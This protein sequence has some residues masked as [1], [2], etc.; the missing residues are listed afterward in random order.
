M[1]A[2]S[3]CEGWRCKGVWVFVTRLCP[4][5]LV[6]IVTA[7]LS[8][9]WPILSLFISQVD[10]TVQKGAIPMVVSKPKLVESLLLSQTDP[11]KNDC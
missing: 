9:C 4:Q 7:V 11:M 6:R 1:H 8:Y 10:F 5:I 2:E 3:V